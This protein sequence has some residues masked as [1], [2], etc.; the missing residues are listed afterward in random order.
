V[1]IVWRYLR[2]PTFSRFDTIPE[3]DRH[4]HTQTDRH[5]TTAYTTLS[6]ALR[7][8]NVSRGITTPLSGTVCCPSAWTGYDQYVPNMFI[9]YD[10]KGN[11]KCKNLGGLEG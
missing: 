3:C 7:G 5:T 11:E 2:D 10:M 6:I 8:K 4:R 9:H 1:A